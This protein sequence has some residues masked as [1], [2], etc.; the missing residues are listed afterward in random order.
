MANICERSIN[1]VTDNKPKML[2]GLS[3]KG[4]VAGTRTLV[5][6]VMGHQRYRWRERE[7]GP[8]HNLTHSFVI[9]AE[10]GNPVCLPIGKANRKVSPWIYGHERMEKANTTL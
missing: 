4:N 8:R 1:I 6:L 5:F 3:Q 2:K 7:V 10:H 9:T